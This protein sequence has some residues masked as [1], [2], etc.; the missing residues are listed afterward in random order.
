PQIPVPSAGIARKGGRGTVRSPLR[1]NVP[2]SAAVGVRVEVTTRCSF[3]C[4][5]SGGTQSGRQTLAALQGAC[6]LR[7]RLCR[8][9]L[10]HVEQRDNEYERC[11][12]VNL[13]PFWRQRV[14]TA[15]IES[16]PA[17]SSS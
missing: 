16:T 12:T 15:A 13:A 4:L 11:S 17:A 6:R 5:Y 10:G 3:T 9:P 8:W 2:L 7:D 1:V 14:A